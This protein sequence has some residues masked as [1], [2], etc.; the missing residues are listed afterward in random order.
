[1]AL[2]RALIR[3]AGEIERLAVDASLVQFL[4]KASALLSNNVPP[5]L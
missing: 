3:R 1:M 4:V 5:A 2:T